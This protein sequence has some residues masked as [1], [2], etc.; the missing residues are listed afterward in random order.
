MYEVSYDSKNKMWEVRGTA[1]GGHVLS[2]E[3]AIARSSRARGS[4][5]QPVG[6]YC[7]LMSVHG[8]VIPPGVHL[9]LQTLRELG[10][11]LP[12]ITRGEGRDWRLLPSGKVE[13]A[14]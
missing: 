12:R 7:R 2:F 9:P 11:G 6:T 10:V 3:Q 1:L 5:A 14:P 4:A 13:R 8:L